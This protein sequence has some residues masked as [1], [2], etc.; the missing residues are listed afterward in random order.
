MLSGEKRVSRHPAPGGQIGPGTRIEG[1]EAH[2]LPRSHGGQSGSE[3]EDELTAA[4]GTSVPGGVGFD[5]GAHDHVT[6]SVVR[7]PAR[8]NRVCR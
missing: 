6:V 3:L 2:D 1:D 8:T 7:S 4:Q 5:V